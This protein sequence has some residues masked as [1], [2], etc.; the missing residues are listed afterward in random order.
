M[1]NKRLHARCLRLEAELE[2]LKERFAVL[3]EEGKLDLLVARTRVV[4][5]S[6]EVREVVSKQ[7]VKDGPTLR[8][9]ERVTVV[10]TVIRESLVVHSDC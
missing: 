3:D 2:N 8:E 10:T 4:R 1:K 7:T 6:I 9:V 5:R